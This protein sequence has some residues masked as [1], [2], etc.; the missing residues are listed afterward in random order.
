MKEITPEDI[1]RYISK[2][3]DEDKE[4]ATKKTAARKRASLSSFFNYLYNTTRIIDRNPVDGAMRVKIPTKDYVEYLDLEEQ[5]IFLNAVYYGT[6]LTNRQL[7]LHNKYAIRDYALFSLAFDTGLRVSEISG[8]DM[9]DIDIEESSII[10]RRKGGKYQKIY[11]GDDTRENILEYIQEKEATNKE[12]NTNA[13]LFTTLKGERLSIRQMQELVKKYATAALPHKAD[14]ISFHKTRSSYAMET[15]AADPNLLNLQ[16]KLGHSNIIATNVYA[17][18]SD[19]QLAES[20]N[21]LQ[22][23]RSALADSKHN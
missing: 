1:N 3:I 13:P 22:S 5:A 21:L 16:R 20:R 15:Y 6:G 17:K 11:F 10:I 7:K 18:A 8:I 12:H 19:K 14:K 2:F 4:A 9:K 23:R